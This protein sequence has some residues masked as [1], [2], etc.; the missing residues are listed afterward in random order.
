MIH[1]WFP[2]RRCTTPAPR[3]RCSYYDIQS[4]CGPCGNA[5]NVQAYR[6]M[7]DEV[8]AVLEARHPQWVKKLDKAVQEA[9]QKRQYEKAAEI[10][11][12]I[13][14][15]RRY[16]RRT[17]FIENF[18][19][20]DLRIRQNKC[21]CKEF[22]VH[23]GVLQSNDLFSLDAALKTDSSIDNAPVDADALLVDRALVVLSWLN[24]SKSEYRFL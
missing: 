8:R 2:L 3:L 1:S 14:L 22:S 24:K 18:K 20:K 23:K 7:V 15:Y 9:S 19:S 6:K 4:C 17:R 16:A 21:S 13:Q 12:Q 11:S 10:H 5:I